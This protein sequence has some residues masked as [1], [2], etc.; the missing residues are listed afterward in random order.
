MAGRPK[1]SRNAKPKDIQAGL[2]AL[3]RLGSSEAAEKETGVKA[4][5]IRRWKADHP[6]IFHDLSQSHAREL[7]ERHAG[8]VQRAWSDYDEAARIAAEKIRTGDYADGKEFRS[9]A[10]TIGDFVRLGDHA[11]RLNAG[12]PTERHEHTSR[13]ELVDEARQHYQRLREMGVDLDAPNLDHTG[14][15][16]H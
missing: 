9:L 14:A 12:Q 16:R 1:G 8:N 6:Q 4:A 2:D 10:Q 3:I 7:E 13:E 15:E 11:A 5:T